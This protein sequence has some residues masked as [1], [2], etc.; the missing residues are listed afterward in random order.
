M[1]GTPTLHSTS[2]LMDLEDQ[3]KSQMSRTA[4]CFRHKSTN[5]E[6]ALHTELQFWRRLRHFVDTNIQDVEAVISEPD[7]YSR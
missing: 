7:V 3:L 5:K 1:T 4:D 2:D 6:S